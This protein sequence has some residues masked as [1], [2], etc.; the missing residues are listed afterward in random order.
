MAG[1]PR[2][3]TRDEEATI[4]RALAAGSSDGEAGRAAG[5]SPRRLYAA[6]LGELSDLPRNKRGPR[7]GRVYAPHPDLVE[8]PVEEIYR[9]AAELRA[10][11]WTEEEAAQ[12]WNPGFSGPPDA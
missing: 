1:R 12:R 10:E 4:R 11:R 2:V 5:V 6:R 3:L 9:R 7:P 8:I